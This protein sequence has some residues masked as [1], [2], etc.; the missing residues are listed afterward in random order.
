MTNPEFGISVG[1]SRYHN[2]TE[3]DVYLH[4]VNCGSVSMSPH[5]ARYIGLQLIMAADHLDAISKEDVNE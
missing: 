2:S 1:F 5:D 3:N 4:M